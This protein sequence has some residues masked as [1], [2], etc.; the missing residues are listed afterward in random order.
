MVV[1]AL[2]ALAVAAAAPAVAAALGPL[3]RGRLEV[4]EWA[5]SV[6]ALPA[7]G[8]AALASTRTS[9]VTGF[10]LGATLVLCVLAAA[11]AGA[12]LVLA[13]F[14]IARRQPDGS[15]A[16][17][18]GPLRGGRVIGILERL[19]VAASILATWPEGIAIVLAVKGLARYPELREPHAS[20]QFIMGTFVSVLWA[21]A[22]RLLRKVPTGAGRPRAAAPGTGISA[23]NLHARAAAAADRATD[24]HPAAAAPDRRI[25]AAR[26]HFHGD[27]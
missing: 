10:A 19:A 8:V 26:A 18:A 24:F 1:L 5:S 13:T 16:P 27:A 20:E 21:I 17:D 25:R 14:K 12:P 22:V 2:I 15:P 6:V 11:T 23:G 3:S 7:L 9:P 4:P